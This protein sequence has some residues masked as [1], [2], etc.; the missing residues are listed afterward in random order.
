[1]YKL[2]SRTLHCLTL[3]ETYRANSEKDPLEAQSE[4]AL[5]GRFKF[6]QPGPYDVGFPKHLRVRP[7]QQKSTR[8][9]TLLRVL[10]QTLKLHNC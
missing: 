3:L 10:L 1:M 7:D 8:D 2:H 4:L 6:L 5:P 9:P